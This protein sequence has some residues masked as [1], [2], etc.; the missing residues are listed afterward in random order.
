[1]EMMCLRESGKDI[2]GMG[3][4][5]TPS[6]FVK[7]CRIF[8]TLDVL[9]KTTL[10]LSEDTTE[11]KASMGGADTEIAPIT[12][13]ETIKS[14]IIT[15]IENKQQEDAVDQRDQ[16]SGDKIRKD[17]QRNH[18]GLCEKKGSV[19]ARERRVIQEVSGLLYD[20][21]LFILRTVAIIFAK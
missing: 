18:T 20:S 9:Y 7:A 8:K 17:W 13:I 1:M 14:A 15:L 2:I 6:A 4:S 19:S 11:E 21:A 5:K 3:E 16:G 10:R 12:S